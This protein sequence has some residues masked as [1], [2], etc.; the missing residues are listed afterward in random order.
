MA[1]PT[2]MTGMFVKGR[3]L[4]FNIN[5]L[6]HLGIWPCEDGA[7]VWKK[8]LNHIMIPV[9]LLQIVVFFVTELIDFFIN[10]GNITILTE[11]MCQMSASTLLIFKIIYTVYRRTQFNKLIHVLENNFFMPKEVINRG[12]KSV[13]EKCDQQTKIF[14]IFY[15]CL[16]FFTGFFW[17]CIPFID[18]DNK[19]NVLPF[20]AW[21]PFDI[22]KPTHYVIA[23][24]FHIIH[25]L[26]FIV[27]IPAIGMFI[28][29][30]IL[31]ACGQFKLL[32]SS[33]IGLEDIVLQRIR[34]ENGMPNFDIRIPV[35]NTGKISEIYNE[36]YN[37]DFAN[38]SGDNNISGR[39]IMSL[40][41]LR[42]L[43]SNMIDFHVDMNKEIFL[44]LK[45]C[46]I[47]HQIIL[48]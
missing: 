18:R 14:T 12:Q 37:N 11:I 40:K 2:S 20:Q 47:H 43:H 44:S 39:P 4:V 8:T 32:Q 42:E 25:S 22:S 21:T 46:I 38:K 17:I 34:T 45:D 30:I 36:R 29:G 1:L 31:H 23:Y 24:T 28:A 48:R 35:S 16:G 9:T 27:Y 3:C 6:R 5:L 13:V 10:W 33:L 26:I 41:N 7:P 15:L 19:G